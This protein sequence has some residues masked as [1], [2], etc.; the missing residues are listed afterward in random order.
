MG[1]ERV[2][3]AFSE[4]GTLYQVE[5]ALEAAK[6]GLP[7]AL[8][9]SKEGIAMAAAKRVPEKLMDT[10]YVSSFSLIGNMVSITSGYTMD[11]QHTVAALKKSY[12][13][14][15]YDI[16]KAPPADILARRTAD[17]WQ[18]LTQKSYRRLPA[19]SMA[20]AECTKEKRSIYYTDCSGVLFPYKGVAFGENAAVMMKCMEK[21]FKDDLSKEEALE[22]VLITL[23]EALGSDYLATHVEVAF[24]DNQN[25][26]RLST[27][28]IDALLVQI[29]EKEQ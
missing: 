26:E 23:S 17:K 27:D 20:I 13:D 28:R 6:K 21:V 12:V 29:A 5:Y 9:V 2:E 24:L 8:A 11:V 4:K 18:E 19:V 25:L 10:E 3:N 1:E 15:K 14:L 16:G 7:C 22:V